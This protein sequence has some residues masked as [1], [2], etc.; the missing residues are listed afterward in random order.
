[1]RA[2]IGERQRTILALLGERG[3]LCLEIVIRTLAQRPTDRREIA[4]AINRLAD[5]GLVTITARGRVR[6]GSVVRLSAGK[7]Q[8]AKT[9]QPT[10]DHR[11]RVPAPPA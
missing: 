11:E 3:G 6:P 4:R 8:P 9:P 7:L 2:P 1:M 10:P 5:A